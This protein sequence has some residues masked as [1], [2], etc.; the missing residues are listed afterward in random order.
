MGKIKVVIDKVDENEATDE[1][2]Q[3]FE[4]MQKKTL[5]RKNVVNKD[6]E[7][8]EAA[9][10]EKYEI[11][12]LPCDKLEDA[13]VNW[14]FFSVPSDEKLIELAAS[15]RYN[16][17]LQPIVVR[18]IP[19]SDRYQILAGHTRR[20]AYNLLYK[21]YKDNQYLSIKAMVFA[22]GI[23]DDN[24]AKEIICDTNYYQRG[25]LPPQE[26]AK[27]ISMKA[28]I[29][30]VTGS[31]NIRGKIAEAYDMKLTTVSQWIRIANLIDEFV[32][33]AKDKNLNI[34]SQYNLAGFS[35][36]DQ[37][38]LYD[39]AKD[40]IDNITSGKLIPEQGVDSAIEYLM[41]VTHTRMKIIRFKD[42]PEKSYR[43]KDVAHLVYVDPKHIDEFNDLIAQFGKAYIVASHKRGR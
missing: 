31:R 37:K 29:L 33:L 43:S 21:V 20:K 8:L 40:Y 15:I 6:N 1:L 25:N 14:N 42:I 3:K 19:G 36:D 26:L 34:K 35:K 30:R 24:R 10:H 16:G 23:I 27:C 38:R 11:I 13:P 22:E 7:K 5:Q 12:S 4:A 9:I 39:E 2:M 32:E 17:L 28:S 41:N 18:K